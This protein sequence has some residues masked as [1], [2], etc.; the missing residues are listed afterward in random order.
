MSAYNETCASIANV[1]WNYRLF[2]LH[3]DAKYFDVLERTLY[4]AFLSGVSLTGDKFFYP[5]P[6]ESHGQHAR[7]PWFSCACCPGNVA[8]FVPSVGGYFYAQKDKSIYVNLFAA[9]S[10]SFKLPGNTVALEQKTNYPW[11]GD[12]Q[13]TVSPE[14]TG[15]FEVRVRIPGWAIN[16]PIPSDLYTFEDTFAGQPEILLNDKPVKLALQQ[17]YV[18][19]NR[20]W[21]KGDRI[22]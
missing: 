14:K 19:F 22:H 5:N 18:V 21:K 20:Q 13:I 1:Y 3:G 7:S 15:P 17:G 16:K 11:N 12:L 8:R 10:A 4:N 9:G 6:L 2:L